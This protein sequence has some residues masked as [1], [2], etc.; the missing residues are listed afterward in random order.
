MDEE[1]PLLGDKSHTTPDI[2]S[3]S[4]RSFI[5]SNIVSFPNVSKLTKTAA[6]KSN[7][8]IASDDGSRLV[9]PSTPVQPG[10]LLVF[11]R[12]FY[13]HCEY[14]TLMLPF[15]MMLASQMK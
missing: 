11:P 10:D 3:D 6:E 2:S 7:S 12:R 8:R 13:D 15:S 9:M 4:T 1:V 5:R 14:D